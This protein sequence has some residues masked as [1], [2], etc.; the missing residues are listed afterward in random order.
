MY[1]ENLADRYVYDGGEKFTQAVTDASK[2][3]AE[4]RLLVNKDDSLRLRI[5]RDIGKMLTDCGLKVTMLEQSTASYEKTLKQRGYDLYLG[6]TKL[7]P[8]MDLSGFF[9]TRGALNA[10]NISDV[11]LNTLCTESLANHGNYYTLHKNVMDDGRLCPILFRS[12]AV[13][14]TRGLLTGLTPSRDNVFYYTLGKT[15]DAARLP[16]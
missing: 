4:V 11:A 13:Y 1:S 8:N 3:N 7:S 16:E 9:A 6:Q 12:Y 10:G 14:A 2:Y 5:A 15:M